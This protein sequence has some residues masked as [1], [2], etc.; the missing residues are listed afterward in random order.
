MGLFE[1]MRCIYERL[2]GLKIQCSNYGKVESG[3]WHSFPFVYVECY[4]H[5]KALKGSSVF[6][7]PPSAASEGHS[8]TTSFDI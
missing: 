5:Q 7:F 6:C 2:K 1:Y 4:N 3:L 8:D